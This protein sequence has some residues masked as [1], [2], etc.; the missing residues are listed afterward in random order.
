MATW[1]AA[2]ISER[3][4]PPALTTHVMSDAT[5]EALIRRLAAA[6]PQVIVVDELRG[7]LGGLGRY[8]SGEASERE[9][10]LAV[11]PGSVREG[12]STGGRCP[13]IVHAPTRTRPG[14]A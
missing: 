14:S 5:P 6:G 4:E 13:V 2:P 12:A 11:Y 7:W 10:G 8:G 3:G 9:I 1:R